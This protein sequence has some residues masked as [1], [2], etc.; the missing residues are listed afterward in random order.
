MPPHGQPDQNTL[1]SFS[2]SPNK[3][4]FLHGGPCKGKAETLAYWTIDQGEITGGNAVYKDPESLNKIIRKLLGES[5][6]GYNYAEEIMP[7]LSYMN[8]DHPVGGESTASDRV[9]R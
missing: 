5:N 9:R 2:G 8:A 7:P 3:K 6:E 1:T 4:H